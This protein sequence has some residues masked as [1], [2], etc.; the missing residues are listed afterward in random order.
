MVCCL[1]KDSSACYITKYLDGI[2]IATYLWQMSYRQ[3]I[4]MK[5]N[6]YLWKTIS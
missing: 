3:D 4:F 1:K 6:K 5:N 2:C